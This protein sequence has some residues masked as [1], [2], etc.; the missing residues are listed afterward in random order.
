MRVATRFEDVWLS[1]DPLG[2][3]DG[4]S[5]FDRAHLATKTLGIL[6]RVRRQSRSTTLGL[7]GPWGSGKTTVL[8]ELVRLLKNPDSDAALLMGEAWGVAQFN[9]W[10]YSDTLALHQGFFAELRAALP[11]KRRW[12]DARSGLARFSRA[13]APL[14]AAAGLLGVDGRAAIEGFADRLESS[15]TDYKARVETKL[16]ELNM[17]ILMVID[18]L[19]RL[20]ADELLHLFR[21]VRLVGRLPN[22][23]YL[24]SYDEHTLT[25]LL[26]K[27][28]L[29]GPSGDR[30]A[31]DYLEKI[32]QIRI[33]IPLL[34]LDEV[35]SAVDRGLHMVAERHHV[36]QRPADLQELQLAFG[37]VLGLR[38]RTP[39]ALK[40]YFGQLDAFLPSVGEE[41]HFGDFA[42]LTW[43]RT[44]EPGVYGLLQAYRALLLGEHRDPLRELGLGQK[45]ENADL[46][47]DWMR[48]LDTARV[49]E[50]DQDDVLYVLSR[51][52]P[53]LRSAYS[54]TGTSDGSSGQ[55]S[56]AGRIANPDYFDRY[57]AFGVPANDIA[58]GLVA[59]A[60]ERIERGEL[61]GSDAAELMKKFEAE[62]DL[63]IRKLWTLAE[64]NPIPRPGLLKWIAD[65]YA[66]NERYGGIRQRIESFAAV[67]TL[68]LEREAREHAV[69]T[70]AR[71][72]AGLYLVGVIQSLLAGARY[73]AAADIDTAHA[74]AAE[75]GP[76]VDT[77]FSMRFVEVAEALS[78]PLMIPA[79]TDALKW[80]WRS[81]DPAGFRDFLR[82]QVEQGRWSLLDELAWLVPT[83][84]SAD[85]G[86]YITR[87]DEFAH[88][89]ELFDLDAAARELSAQL[90]SAEITRRYHSI[91]ATD[92]NRRGY[93]L[94]LL[95]VWRDQSAQPGSGT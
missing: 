43:L 69:E 4:P 6:A 56:P 8:D 58:D 38:L 80:L 44:V 86:Q 85:Q 37:K 45:I 33:D 74:V 89:T 57:F 73:G 25:D 9:P 62:P 17:P 27:T 39:R 90:E 88:F 82:A 29:V 36:L 59:Q 72:D 41:V 55:D 32:V 21:L 35:D 3:S 95:R 11:N 19:D 13:V 76:A 84:I 2:E 61:D 12:N 10:L 23:Y 49:A 87:F 40:R 20:S 30:R 67:L 7:I 66:K 51:L 28:D 18:D 22:V 81:S 50:A 53:R 79:D 71:T 46:R 78:T 92:E 83:T 42:V 65:E 94:A 14:G 31:L 60:A 75:I 34:R 63:I 47:A 48:R 54:G 77:R 15:V 70:L 1:D 93:A 5:E 91:E 16:R 68:A 24:L 64:A 26:S 52:F